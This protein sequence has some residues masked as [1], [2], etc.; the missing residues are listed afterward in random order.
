MRFACLRGSLKERVS[1]ALVGLFLDDR[2]R[3][4]TLLTCANAWSKR[5]K[6]ARRGGRRPNALR[7]PRARIKWLRRWY[8]TGSVAAMPTEGS[9][10]PLEEH[11][12]CRLALVAEQPKLTLEEVVEAVYKQRIASSRTAV[13]CRVPVAGSAGVMA[14]PGVEWRA[15]ARCSPPLWKTQPTDGT[16]PL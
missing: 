4:L 11:A 6:R 8:E 14:C 5:S 2:W 1:A 9:V 15:S 3:G 10:S 12:T 16:N 13:W 7:S